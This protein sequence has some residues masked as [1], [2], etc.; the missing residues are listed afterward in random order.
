MICLCE[1]EM[2]TNLSF[3]MNLMK[4]RFGGLGI[5]L[6]QLQSESSSEPNPL[7]GGITRPSDD[8]A[9]DL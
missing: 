7:Y 2:T 9:F 3:S 5:K 8:G 6:M 4:S 1:I